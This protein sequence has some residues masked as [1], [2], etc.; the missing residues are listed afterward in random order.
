MTEAG[1]S[2]SRRVVGMS[3]VRSGHGR[4]APIPLA[5]ERTEPGTAS[6]WK[7]PRR[8]VAL[9]AVEVRFARVDDVLASSGGALTAL[10]TARNQRLRHPADRAAHR[11]AHLLVRRVAARLLAAP[12]DEVEIA[13]LCPTCGGTDHG[14]P[15]VVGHPSLFVSLSHTRD[16]VAAI[17]AHRPCGIDVEPVRPVTDALRHR[18]LTAAEL[19][20]VQTSED[21]ATTFTRIWAAKE[22]MVKAGL[23]T[24]A[25]AATWPAS[26]PSLQQWTGG[27]P[28]TY[29]PGGTR[30]VGAWLVTP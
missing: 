27:T 21:P 7:D 6:R 16:R 15:H 14:R 1:R 5:G 24:L 2:D 28:N 12:A 17:A 11:A 29:S 4:T 13:Q 20:R 10:E 26:A 19:R 8:P 22:A 3:S 23:G 9:P 25:D 30:Y 18:V